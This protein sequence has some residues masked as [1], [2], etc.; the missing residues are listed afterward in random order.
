LGQ[1]IRQKMS[2]LAVA[3]RHMSRL[4][5]KRPDNVA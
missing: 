1:R 2:Q 3:E 4:P 5:L